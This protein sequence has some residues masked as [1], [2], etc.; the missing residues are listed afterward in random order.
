MERLEEFLR[1]AVALAREGGENTVKYFRTELEV[2]EKHDSSPV[3]RADR[4]TESLMFD[5]IRAAYP[6]HGLIGE[7]SGEFGADRELCWVVDPIDGTKSFVNG[8]PLYTVLVALLWR[9]RP[10]LGVIHQPVL[11]ETVWAAEGRG[12]FFNGAPSRI[13]DCDG[14]DR[15]WLLVTDPTDLLNTWSGSERLLR[16]ARHCR[17]WGDGYG[18]LMLASGRADLMIDARMNLWDVACLVPIVQEAG[19]VLCDLRGDPG[20]GQSAIAGRVAI[21]E[22]ALGY[23]RDR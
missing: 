16:A 17:T 9:G 4:E 23:L 5:R 10:V 20:L 15:A 2:E 14:L 11:G 7:E 19:G 21:V 13:R 12:C 22:Q 3:T 8:I 18:Y 6:D 1:F